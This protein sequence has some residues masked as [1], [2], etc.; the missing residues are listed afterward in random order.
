VFPPKPG[1]TFP[2]PKPRA[3]EQGA[4]MAAPAGMGLAAGGRMKQKVYPDPYGLDTWDQ[5]NRGRFVCHIVNSAQYRAL[6]GRETPPAPAAA[7]PYP[8]LGLPR[9][10]LYDDDRADL[11]A[12]DALKRIKSVGELEPEGATGPDAGTLDVPP[13]QVEKL[14]HPGEGGRTQGP[15]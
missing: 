15:G 6:T 14:E 5:E 12:P 7:A 8:K 11:A 10:D 3:L 9:F 4:V 1:R 2:R 13:E